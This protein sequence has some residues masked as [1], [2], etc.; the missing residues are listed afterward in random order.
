MFGGTSVTSD[1]HIQLCI[2]IPAESGC[3][4]ISEGRFEDVSGPSG[5]FLLIKDPLL[6][7]HDDKS[8]GVV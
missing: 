1:P 2:L 3:D 4:V 8:A 5:C 7:E 6:D